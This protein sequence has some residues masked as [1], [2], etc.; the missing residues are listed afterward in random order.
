MANDVIQKF[1][2]LHAETEQLL[3]Q[4]RVKEAKRKYSEVLTAYQAI[5]KSMMEHYHK[6][7]AY[8][9]VTT[10]YRKVNSAKERVKIPYN[11]IIAAVLVIAFSVLIVMK[12]SIVGL[13]SLEDAVKQPVSITFTET[14]VEQVTLRDKPLSLSAGGQFTGK[15]KLYLKQGQQFE[16]IFD[17]E[18]SPSENGRF[19]NICEETCEIIVGSN[20]IELFAQIESGSLTVTE[21]NYNVEKTK[22]SAPAWVGR[23]RTFNAKRGENLVLDLSQQYKDP[24][25]DQLVFLSTTAEGLEVTV[26][27]DKVTIIPKT[28]GEKKITFLLF[29]FQK[30]L[31]LLSCKEM[32]Q[33]GTRV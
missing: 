24:E 17:S 12:P 1:V 20:A 31:V 9:Q 22:N 14:R 21:L 5:D 30:L 4:D 2:A 7:L 3:N 29:L 8:D 18:T 32:F 6:E 19:V 23:T 16:L 26:Q 27:H 10:L 11:L 25:N 28:P 15:V 13:A 33:L